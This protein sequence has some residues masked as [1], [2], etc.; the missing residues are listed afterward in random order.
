MYERQ[1]LPRVQPFARGLKLSVQCVGERQIHVVATQQN[2]F[3]DADA[4]KFQAPLDVCDRDQ[5]EIGRPP[6]D[7]A[8]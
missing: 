2:V 3:A 6:T 1:E 7:I 4:L 8:D 5:T